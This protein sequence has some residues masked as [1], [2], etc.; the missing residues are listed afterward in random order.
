MTNLGEEILS[1]IDNIDDVVMES[2][3]NVL[4]T[5]SSLC[6]KTMMIKSNTSEQTFQEYFVMEANVFSKVGNLFKTAC[7]AF[8]SLLKRI[9]EFF[10]RQ[11]RKIK[12]KIKR[13]GSKKDKDSKTNNTS[14]QSTASNTQ[15][16][17]VPNTEVFISMNLTRYKEILEK[18][19][20][21]I[22]DILGHE[23]VELF[24]NTSLCSSIANS[25]NS[26]ANE[27]VSDGETYKFDIMKDKDR[28]SEITELIAKNGDAFSKLTSYIQPM[29]KE[30]DDSSGEEK[31]L[32]TNNVLA[33]SQAYQAWMKSH[34][35]HDK[36]Y[37]KIIDEISK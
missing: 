33:L 15:T 8:I 21:I 27:K 32:M 1:A 10:K 28:A 7:E 26:I 2:E 29:K 11:Y 20:N 3:I 12:D 16:D 25:F 23:A 19:L 24:K 6:T 36:E 34:F 9:S 17:Q 18:S 31:T 13:I 4:S 5:M 30:I 22:N 14:N 37:T 35:E